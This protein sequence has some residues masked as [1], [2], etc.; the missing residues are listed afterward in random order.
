MEIN[1]QGSVTLITPQG[2]RYSIV[3]ILFGVC[4][5]EETLQ[6]LLYYSS[7]WSL[8]ESSSVII[9]EVYS[10]LVTQY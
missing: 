3:T 7:T 5:W 4:F 6:V 1:E 2:V 8:K 10:Q 9:H